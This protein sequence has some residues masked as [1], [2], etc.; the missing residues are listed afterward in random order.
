M[1]LRPQTKVYLEAL[2]DGQD[3]IVKSMNNDPSVMQGVVADFKVILSE[4]YRTWKQPI[5]H[6]DYGHEDQDVRRLPTDFDGAGLFVCRKHWEEG[7]GRE[8]YLLFR[9]YGRSRDQVSLGRVRTTGEILKWT[10]TKRCA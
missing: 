5:G 8:D 9:W 2:L 7:D 10:R 3:D 4:I 1:K 6:C